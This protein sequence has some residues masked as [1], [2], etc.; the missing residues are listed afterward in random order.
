MPS[1]SSEPNASASAW[2]QSMPPSRIGG[3]PPLEL[4]PELG[5][6][7]EALRQLEQRVGERD[8]LVGRGRVRVDLVEVARHALAG[9]ALG[10]LAGLGRV[11]RVGELLAASARGASRRRPRR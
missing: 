4:R 1:F 8:Q 10:L 3:A 2:P 7:R 9:L 6:H 11:V 5:V